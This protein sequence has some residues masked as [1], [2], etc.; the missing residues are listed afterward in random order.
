M[1]PP[2]DLDKMREKELYGL[3]LGRYRST[4]KLEAQPLRQAATG[5]EYIDCR[6]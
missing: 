2:M 6:L 4:F 1:A 5:T 3:R